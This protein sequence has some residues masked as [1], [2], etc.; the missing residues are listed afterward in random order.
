MNP[1]CYLFLFQQAVHFI[2]EGSIKLYF[3]N[4]SEKVKKMIQK[5]SWMPNMF[6]EVR[7][8]NNGQIY[9]ENLTLR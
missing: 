1:K 8:V 9:R 4:I 5:M 3:F 7:S 6:L 2:Q